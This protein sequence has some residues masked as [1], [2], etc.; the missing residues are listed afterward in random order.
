MLSTL[1]ILVQYSSSYRE[2]NNRGRHHEKKLT[3]AR[4]SRLLAIPTSTRSLRGYLGLP[5]RS[6][7]L[8]EVWRSRIKSDT[9]SYWTI[10]LI[11][12]ARKMPS[13]ILH[14]SKLLALVL[15]LC[16]ALGLATTNDTTLLTT[17]TRRLAATSTPTSLFF[18]RH[19][20]P[21]CANPFYATKNVK[22]L[23]AQSQTVP[24][25]LNRCLN[26]A[27]KN[28]KVTCRLGLNKYTL[29]ETR[30]A[31]GDTSC[32]TPLLQPG[33][34]SIMISTDH[35]YLCQ[36]D[37][38]LGT[39]TKIHCG[40]D[41]NAAL[42]YPTLVSPVLYPNSHC[43]GRGGG[44]GGGGGGGNAL[45]PPTPT[46]RQ[47]IYLNR[48]LPV[49]GGGHAI[50]TYAIVS[51]KTWSPNGG[52]ELTVQTFAK[53]DFNCSKPS[54]NRRS[55]TY[56]PVPSSS[57][58]G[59]APAC[60]RD[61]FFSKF[62][63]LN[64]PGL[65][66]FLKLPP[67][68]AA[69]TIAPTPSPTFISP[70]PVPTAS[71]TYQT[72]TYRFS[73]TSSKGN[74][75]ES[76]VNGY[77]LISFQVADSDASA[78]S[79]TTSAQFTFTPTSYS[80][81]AQL[82]L[83]GGGGGGGVWGGGGGAGQVQFATVSL[84]A[85]QTYS[86]T[87]G[88]GGLSMKLP[89][90]PAVYKGGDSSITG[91]GISMTSYGG[92]GG[93]GIDWSGLA[94]ITAWD[95]NP[96]NAYSTAPYGSGGGGWFRGDLPHCLPSGPGCTASA[97]S[98]CSAGGDGISGYS[99]YNEPSGGGGGAGGVGKTA[100]VPTSGD[101]GPGLLWPYSGLYYAGGGGGCGSCNG[102]V[103]ASTPNPP[104]FGGR[105]GGGAGGS[106]SIGSA[107]VA[108]PLSNGV[109]GAIHT[110]SGGGGGS[111]G[112]NACVNNNPCYAGAGGKGGSGIAI[113]AVPVLS[114]LQ[115]PIA[116][117]STIDI[118]VVAGGGGGG[119]SANGGRGS[120]GGAGG[121]IY[122][123]GFP[124]GGSPYTITVGA[125]GPLCANT[126]GTGCQPGYDSVFSGNGRTLT[127]LGGGSG[128]NMDGQGI[129]QAGGS[130]AG[131]WYPGYAG[132]LA[133]QSSSTNDG[134]TVWPNSGFGNPGGIS[135]NAQPYGGGGGGAGGPGGNWND[136]TL[137]PVGGIGKAFDISGVSTYY[138]GGGGNA[139]YT[140]TC[141]YAG[142]LGGGGKGDN[143]G[144]ATDSAGVPNTGGGGGS[145]GAGGSGVI[146]IRYPSSSPPLS[147]TPGLAFSLKNSGGNWIYSFTAGSGSV[148]FP[149]QQ[150]PTP[151]PTA[152][153]SS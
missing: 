127:A 81:S 97:T 29:F 40:E 121:L 149:S 65:A 3:Q 90:N 50:D 89:P 73:T 118:L 16:Q 41:D 42:S 108:D 23:N 17:T 71:P 32:T 98:F 53:P 132:G 150:T 115:N 142:G 83:V 68:S 109:V 56:P 122:I 105:G 79:T 87:V 48:C 123:T 72:F 113:L 33:T 43:G 55:I 119:T 64:A 5:A 125:G 61:P 153:P 2:L 88:N 117:A 28:F 8:D 143:L 62:Y 146:I 44:G 107:G 36:K 75:T 4:A 63:Y 10:R 133:T 37:A 52:L 144:T 35:Q 96:M 58:A 21:G 54:S 92:A 70:T 66:P 99:F 31:P 60:L 102:R 82:L 59:V 112:K 138:A 18:T 47:Q 30:F 25:V 93:A 114:L 74:V 120:P 104:G 84:T 136:A 86:I 67:P 27:D 124:V 110:G 57:V 77:K 140:G 148:V 101:G 45:P 94:S 24:I 151:A 134:I 9:W 100:T 80:L 141:R 14:A 152:L 46:K 145:G 69:P 6:D 111:Y 76:V 15:L 51:Q 34:G 12:G 147:V 38:E 1:L 39:Y 11:T 7:T 131:P 135:G 91:P 26:S 129:G 139:C 130:G 13:S 103:V 116:A 22:Y 126:G 85:G 128:K 137:G 106:C 95:S 49:Y 20:D 78:T 19:T